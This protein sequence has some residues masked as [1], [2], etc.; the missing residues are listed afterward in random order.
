MQIQKDQ[1]NDVQ[2]RP[3]EELF[4]LT[5]QLR[6]RRGIERLF[7]V[8]VVKLFVLRALISIRDTI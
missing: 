3:G 2:F 4:I 7:I 6:K 5:R 1:Q 8:R